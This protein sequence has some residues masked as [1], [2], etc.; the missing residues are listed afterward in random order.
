M[1]GSLKAEW[2]KLLTTRTFYWLSMSAAL[3][4]ASIGFGVAAQEPPPWHVRTE[5]FEA[6]GGTS[7]IIL[8]LFCLIV[9]LRSFTEE[10]RYGT[11]VHTVFA[12]PHHTRTSLAKAMVAAGGGVAL[13]AV[14]VILTG[15]V[16][17]VMTL[18][19]G[20]SFEVTGA[21][22]PALGLVGGG[23]LWSVIG[24]GLGAVV[25]QPVAAMVAALLWVLVIEN[26]AGLVIG[27]VARYLPSQTAQAMARGIGEAS[28]VSLAVGVMAAW[29]AAL[30]VAGW[31]TTRRRDLL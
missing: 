9:G 17:Y 22:A 25:R 27:P 23:A 6:L 21:V 19:G 26:V 4:T 16:L 3:L 7:A 5:H 20:G 11:I 8:G 18:L 12:D 31:T 15:M 2:L 28:D 10:H 1:I 24:V 13:S 29:A 14:S 30:L